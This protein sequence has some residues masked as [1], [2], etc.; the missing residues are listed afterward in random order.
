[1]ARRWSAPKSEPEL[2]TGGRPRL[3][4]IL[5]AYRDHP[6][7]A[8]RIVSRARRDGRRRPFDERDLAVARDHGPTDQNHV[9]GARAVLG[10]AEAAGITE[11]SRVLDIGSGLGGS[12]RVLAAT[13]GCR[14]V[15]IDASPRRHRDAVRL[16]RL[17]GLDHL[18]ALRLGDVRAARAGRGRYD[19]VWGQGSWIHLPDRRALLRR[20]A[21][22]LVPGGRV[23][24]EEAILARPP[25]G[26]AER[27][28][29]ARLSDLWNCDIVRDISWFTAC[30]AAGLRVERVD[31]LTGVMH[32]DMS[33]RAGARDARSD[34]RP[35]GRERL[36]SR[37]AQHLVEDGVLGHSRVIALEGG[38]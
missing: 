17:V 6:L 31:D 19:V 20:A 25:R 2:E 7:G 37:L 24:F 4:R 34:P 15:G 26:P 18:V 22:W 10:L 8:G 9:G 21:L 33:A 13:Y 30:E 14:V 29:L 38:S 28:A 5:E 1:M 16:T 35:T 3:A 12:A 23:A 11:R 27:S 32:R 36:A